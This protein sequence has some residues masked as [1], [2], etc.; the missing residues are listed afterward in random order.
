MSSSTIL[1]LV[2]RHRI[3]GYSAYQP[4]RDLAHAVEGFWTYATP[5]TCSRLAG[6]MHRVLPDPSM[7]VAFCLRRQA[8]GTP[9]DARVVLIGEKTRPKVFSYE[10]HREIVAVRIKV[11]WVERLLGL[12]PRE[13][14]DADVD[15]GLILPL[16]AEQLLD[17][18]S[19][20]RTPWDAIEILRSVVRQSKARDADLR[21]AVVTHALDVVR[22]S[23]GRCPVER[24]ADRAGFSVRH[25]RRLVTDST[26]V[27]LKGFARTTRFVA[28]VTAADGAE[29]PPWAQI[30]ADAG[31]YDQSHL[32]RDCQEVC[33]M[34]PTELH[35]E[36]R[37]QVIQ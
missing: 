34:T 30:A 12:R 9:S 29:R 24:I 32:V 14:N 37:A 27:S 28:A 4:T 16:L 35:R 33:G 21:H 15:L 36:R 7:S 1:P 20:T 6:A 23:G 10:R 8:D 22:G 31:F 2:L 25:L 26:G 19:H 11:E 18:L 3:G 17:R 13:H 5:P